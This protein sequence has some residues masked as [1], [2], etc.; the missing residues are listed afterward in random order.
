ML[1]CRYVFCLFSPF[2]SVMIKMATPH[3]LLLAQQA[4]SFKKWQLFG[5]SVRAK[6]SLLCWMPSSPLYHW[7]GHRCS[8]TNSTDWRHTSESS[9][10]PLT[11][12][13]CLPW[14]YLLF[15]LLTQRWK[16]VH[17]RL[18]H[19]FLSDHRYGS[20]IFIYQHFLCWA[21]AA[22]SKL[23]Y[24]S[25]A[26]GA[27]ELTTLTITTDHHKHQHCHGSSLLRIIEP[28]LTPD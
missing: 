14:A 20:H 4:P 28:P 18:C 23:K 25:L 5:V 26:A 3:P 12:I 10:M 1:S 9:G 2:N 27:H 17:H 7:L 6:Q 22:S 11:S 21:A 15:H 13:L 8:C 24:S 19:Y 16:W